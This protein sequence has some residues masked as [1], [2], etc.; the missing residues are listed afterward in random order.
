MGKRRIIVG[1]TIVLAI[2]ILVLIVGYQLMHSTR[3]SMAESW[4]FKGA[5]AKYEGQIDSLS[6]PGSINETIQVIDLNATH[7]QIQTNSSITTSFAPTLTDQT[8]LWVNK[9]NINFQ[10]KGETLTGTYNTKI[11]VRSVGIREC[12]VYDYTNEAINATYY[13][14]KVLLWPVRIVYVTIFENQTYHI[15]FSLKDTNINGLN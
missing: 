13:I 6:I 14:D 15:E 5:Y 3:Q 11:T 7:V 8:T 1:F 2:S 4:M 9:T 10:P 12:T